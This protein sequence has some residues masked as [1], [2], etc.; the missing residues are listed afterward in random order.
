[1]S[2]GIRTQAVPIQQHNV[3]TANKH[4]S[5]IG[6]HDL[7]DVLTIESD[8]LSPYLLGPKLNKVGLALRD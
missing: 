5:N 1:M 4:S 3:H 7:Y 6:L 2:E 8:F